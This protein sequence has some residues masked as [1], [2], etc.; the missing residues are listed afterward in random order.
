MI[1]RLPPTNG[2]RSDHL[3]AV[4]GS[5]ETLTC[6]ILDIYFEYCFW[7]FMITHVDLI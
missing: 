3:R 7:I 5:L 2:Y 6:W 1:T 4:V